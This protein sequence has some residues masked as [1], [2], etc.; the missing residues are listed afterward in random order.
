MANSFDG[1]DRI[2]LFNKNG[3]PEFLK[4]Y[5]HK[6]PPTSYKEKDLIK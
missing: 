1:D 4:K 6:K 2:L 5:T 3:P